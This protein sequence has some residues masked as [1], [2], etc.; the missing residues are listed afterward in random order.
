MYKLLLLFEYIYLYILFYFEVV[1]GVWR[2]ID[3]EHCWDKKNKTINKTEKGLDFILH[4]DPK[5]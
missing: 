3:A 2:L 4:M 1:A 5:L